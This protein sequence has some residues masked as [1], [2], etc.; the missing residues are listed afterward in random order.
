MKFYLISF[1]SLFL[2]VVCHIETFAAGGAVRT[3]PVP[4]NLQFPTLILKKKPALNT[5]EAERAFYLRLSLL[6]CSGKCIR[7]MKVG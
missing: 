7:G 3:H 1:H 6:P 5:N 4:Q 2:V